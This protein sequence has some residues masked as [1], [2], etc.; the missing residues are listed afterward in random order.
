MNNTELSLFILVLIVGAILLRK[1]H[2]HG[3]KQ[4]SYYENEAIKRLEKDFKEI[5]EQI[6]NYTI[7]RHIV[8][9]GKQHGWGKSTCKEM[10]NEIIQNCTKPTLGS[11]D[12]YYLSDYSLNINKKL[13]KIHYVI[14]E[15]DYNFDELK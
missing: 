9:L 12:V 14:G 5:K 1:A 3:I 6:N 10:K 8:W 15:N 2:L 4:K 13:K 11:G 7:Y